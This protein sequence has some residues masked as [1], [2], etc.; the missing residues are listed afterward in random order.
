M[1]TD[2]PDMDIDSVHS[3]HKSLTSVQKIMM[4]VFSAT[5]CVGGMSF[6]VMASYLPQNHHKHLVVGKY[7]FYN[8]TNEI[9]GSGNVP[10]NG[11]S[12]VSYVFDNKIFENKIKNNTCEYTLFFIKFVMYAKEGTPFY[13]SCLVCRFMQGVGFVGIQ[14]STFSIVT[15]EFSDY[16]STFVGI[17]EMA[18]GVGFS[19][20]PSL[21]GFVYDLN[22][23]NTIAGLGFG[24]NAVLYAGSAVLIGYLVD[25]KPFTQGISQKEEILI[26]PLNNEITVHCMP[27]A[28][29]GVYGAQAPTPPNSQSKLRFFKSQIARGDFS[30]F[31]HLKECEPDEDTMGIISE[32]LGALSDDLNH[33]FANL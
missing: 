22:S 24:L 5:I 32:H 21:G 14:I 18:F 2:Q 8:L 17:L 23:T 26:K 10:K 11:Y 9:S 13:A 29:G 33:R 7:F 12:S 3:E 16:L 4:A 31:T 30:R 28:R 19:I 6:S 27:V 25:K 20:G 1:A 15:Q